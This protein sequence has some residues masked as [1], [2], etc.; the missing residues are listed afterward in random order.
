MG[1]PDF[2]EFFCC[3]FLVPNAISKIFFMKGVKILALIKSWNVT[4]FMGKVIK[5]DAICIITRIWKTFTPFSKNANLYMVIFQKL[6]L[7]HFGTRIITLQYHLQ[8]CSQMFLNILK[9]GN[10]ASFI[11]KSNHFRCNFFITGHFR[12]FLRLFL[13]TAI[14]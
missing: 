13:K 10:I 1:L 3:F 7:K 5:I 6:H 4:N 8:R 2:C 12:I 14:R 9:F 11:G